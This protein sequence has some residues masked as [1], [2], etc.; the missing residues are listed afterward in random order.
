MIYY[1]FEKASY[2]HH[3]LPDFCGVKIQRDMSIVFFVLNINQRINLIRRSKRWI[4]KYKATGLARS[5]L[6]RRKDISIRNTEI[7]DK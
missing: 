6:R 7:E 4:S 5:K 3:V 1:V 2:I